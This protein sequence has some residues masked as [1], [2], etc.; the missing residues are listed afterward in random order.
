VTVIT[1]SERPK[2]DATPTEARPESSAQS[3]WFD[4]TVFP[5]TGG[6]VRIVRSALVVLAIFTTSLSFVFP[7]E[8][9]QE[10]AYDGT[11]KLFEFGMSL[12]GDNP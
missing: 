5:V 1:D 6:L 12:Q 3:A 9:L 4:R 8:D 2:R 11:T 7:A 10:T